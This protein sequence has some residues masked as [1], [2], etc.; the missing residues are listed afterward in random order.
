MRL[1]PKEIVLYTNNGSK[2]L[3]EFVEDKL[4]TDEGY[5]TKYGWNELDKNLLPG[6]EVLKRKYFL[7][8]DGN[9]IELSHDV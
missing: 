1:W 2:L 7:R 9:S 4:I 5:R 8:D 3:N 6:V